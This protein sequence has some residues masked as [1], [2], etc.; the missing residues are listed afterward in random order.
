ALALVAQLAQSRLD[1]RCDHPQVGPGLPEQTRLA[2]GDI[3]TPNQE[4]QPTIQLM[5]QRQKIHMHFSEMSCQ[6]QLRVGPLSPRG[7]ERSA[8]EGGSA[9][10]AQSRYQP[11]RSSPPI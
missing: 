3:T 10:P 1:L 5:K 2:Q 7:C 11:I 6:R 9:A 8:A 4:Y